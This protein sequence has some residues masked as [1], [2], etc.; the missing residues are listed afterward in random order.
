MKRKHFIRIWDL[1]K[2]EALGLINRALELKR[3]K[4]WERKFIGKILGLIFEKP[5]TRTRISFES[6]MIKWG[7]SSIF[8]SS[9]DLQLS[10]GEP[11]KDTAR[12]IS[13][14][15]DI[16]VLRTYKQETIEEF[17][18]YSSIPVINGLSDRFHPCQVLSDIMTV[19]EKGKDLYKDKI[20]WIGD[21]NNVA[22]SWIEASAL[23]GFKLVLACP[24][25]FEPEEELLKEAKEIYKAQIEIVNDPEEAI[26]GAKVINTDVWVSMGQEEES[27]KRRFAFKN[28]QVNNELL[29]LADP[30]AIVLHCLPAHRDEEITEEVLEG[31]QSVVWD[32]AENK[33]W[34]H[35]ALIE[36]LLESNYIY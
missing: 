26:K 12:V 19:I 24:K 7:G 21:G 1:K 17:A 8:L 2:E 3:N 28:F 27:E 23:L 20:V 32:Q 34:L 16:L 4:N 14:Y 5:S 10:R 33:M 35:M 11:I 25:G 13:R 9:K 22:Q 6:A 30:S 18:K 31:H 36:F 29:K 15:I